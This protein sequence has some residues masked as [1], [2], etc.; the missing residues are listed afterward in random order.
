[1]THQSQQTQP[2]RQPLHSLHGLPPEPLSQAARSSRAAMRAELDAAVRAR[3]AR[4]VV[5]RAA[6]AVLLV[7]SVA[8]L[9]VVTAQHGP[10]SGGH[11]ARPIA[12][13]PAHSDE[14]ATAIRP[15]AKDLSPGPTLA[16]DEAATPVRS[17]LVG[18]IADD[19]SVLERFGAA[20]TPSRAITLDDRSLLAELRSV[21][22]DAGLVRTEGHARLAFHHP[23]PLAPD[24]VQ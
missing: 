2:A 6:A 13:G 24:P 16:L 20:A 1:M 18:Y 5:T 15:A 7:A 8:A 4:C 17:T 14:P 3:G 9:G 19:P 12:S 22:L 23:R 21:G 11:G 10:R